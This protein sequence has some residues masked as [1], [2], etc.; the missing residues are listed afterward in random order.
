MFYLK[1]YIYIF[2]LEMATPKN[3]HCANCI[4]T[5]SFPNLALPIH[6]RS[7]CQGLCL[8]DSV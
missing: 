8:G 6:C 5:L 2:A 3:L 7:V 4:D 1:K